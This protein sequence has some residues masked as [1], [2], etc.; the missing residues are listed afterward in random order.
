MAQKFNLV[1]NAQ[2]FVWNDPLLWPTACTAVKMAGGSSTSLKVQES[3]ILSAETETERRDWIRAIKQ[4]LYSDN[5]GG[6]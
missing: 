2:S 5:G 3:Y 1:V 6:M 4:I